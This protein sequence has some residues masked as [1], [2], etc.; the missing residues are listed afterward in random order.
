M[1]AGPS[2]LLLGLDA[3]GSRTRAVLAGR[4]GEVV[5]QG[6]GPAA[7]VTR[8]GVAGAAEVVAALWQEA[9]RARP[10]A[11]RLLEAVAGGFAGARA[12]TLQSALREVLTPLFRSAVAPKGVP[13]TV[14]HDAEVA[15][16]G[17]HG[18]RRPAAAVISG[19]GSI[20]VL[21]D[22]KGRIVLAGGWGWPLGDEGSAVWLGWQAVRRALQVWEE[23][24]PD[25]LTAAVLEAWGLHPVEHEDPHV[26][27]RTA[28]EARHR[29][30][31][32]G[33]LA[34]VV[35]R[36]A[37]DGYPPAVE[38]ATAAG[39]ELGRLLAEA[40]RRAMMEPDQPL[41]VAL[42][43]GLGGAW[44]T[45]LE[46]PVR[47]GAGDCGAALDLVPPR[48]EGAWGAVVLAALSIGLPNPWDRGG[49]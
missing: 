17:A 30:E 10:D 14:T 25:E 38:L 31:H 37:A 49:G 2:A 43:G 46:R 36:L 32:F 1:A 45:E 4:G 29:P 35:M 40:A 33:R 23:G 28:A 15:L 42:L 13:V 22:E 8:S 6:E 21:G 12:L 16:L 11:P 26:L 18:T 44:R 39:R 20:A 34:P 27:M 9:E 24:Q 41:P 48:H 47:E 19:T 5:W 7:S 3:G